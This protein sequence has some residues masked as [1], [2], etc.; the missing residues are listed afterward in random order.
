MRQASAPNVAD[1]SCYLLCCADGTLYCGITKDLARRLA[2]HNAG[3]GAKYTRGRTPV[4][5][6]YVESCAGKSSALKREMQIK[7]LPRSKKL[8]LSEQA[9]AAAALNKYHNKQ[10][11]S[12][13]S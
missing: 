4:Q 9:T 11:R 5:L 10:R 2:D 6:I 12:I 8:E 7:K 13:A 3:V 1:W